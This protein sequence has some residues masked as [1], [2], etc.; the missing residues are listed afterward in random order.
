MSRKPVILLVALLVLVGPLALV[1]QLE[2]RV[3]SARP[4]AGLTIALDPGHGGVDPGALGPQGVHEKDIVLAI[5]LKLRE[6]LESCGA[7]VIMTREIDTDLSDANLGHQYSRRKRQDLS[8]R[9]ALINASRAALLVSV[10]L[11][12]MAAR[13]WYGAQVFFT[14][15]S[16]ES[17]RLAVIL[18]ESLRET[19]Q[20]TNRVAAAGDYYILEKT[21][22]P[23][24][25]VEA[26]FIS[27]PEEARLLQS[28]H[29]QARVA[30]AIYRG[31]VRFMAR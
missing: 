22:C 19:L 8:R 5:A 31:V 14:P 29:Y 3:T 12:S 4:L 1:R 23:A 15:E 20:N 27:N 24:V 30:L 18:Q 16:S 25:I 13:R 26:G 28:E 11:N 17:T 6:L 7:T 9:V 10:H 21:T 2:V